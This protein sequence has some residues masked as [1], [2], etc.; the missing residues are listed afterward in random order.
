MQSITREA[1]VAAVARPVIQAGAGGD[2]ARRRATRFIAVITLLST[3]MVV[4]FLLAGHTNGDEIWG[5]I[6][7]AL[8]AITGALS[9]VYLAVN[10]RNRAVR[11]GLIA[12]WLTVAFFGFGGYQSHRLPLPEGTV[13]SRPRPP[14]SPLMFTGIGIAGAIN[15]RS[16]SKGS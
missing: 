4:D 7:A 6:T 3:A 5:P 9:L 2:R 12:V 13:D 11:F 15:L 1:H 10:G 16:G 8:A 14:L